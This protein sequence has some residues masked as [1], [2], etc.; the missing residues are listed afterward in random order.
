[1]QLYGLIFVIEDCSCPVPLQNV[2]VEANI[3]DMI[4]ETMVCQTYK[5]VEQNTI[6]AI[7]KF[8]LHEAAAVCGFE[9]EIDGK[10][11][12]KG[13][14]KKQSK[15]QRSHG[16]YLLEEQHPDIFQCSIGNITAGQTKLIPDK[17]SYTDKTDYY[18]KLDIICRMT[19]V[20]QSIE[21]PSHH[22][23][24]E[25]NIDGNPNVSKITL[26]EQIT[27]LEKDLI[28]VKILGLDQPRSGSMRGGPIK[29]ASETLQLLLRSL[30]ENCLFNV[31]FENSRNDMPTSIFLLTN[32]QVYNVDQI[33]ELIKSSEEKKKDD[34]RLFSI[35]IGDS[36]SHH[37]VESFLMLPPIKDYNI[38]WTNQILE[39]VL[40]IETNTVKRPNISF[41]SDN[42]TPLP[43]IQN[44]FM[45]IKIQQAPFLILP[46]YPGT[47]FIVYCILEKGVEPCKE[48]V[49]SAISQDG[50][51][52]LS[53]PLDPITLRGS[54]IHTLSARKLIQDI[55]EGTSFINKHPRNKEK[56]FFRLTYF[57]LAI[58]E[59]GSG[60]VS[61]AKLLSGQRIDQRI[62]PVSAISYKSC[63]DLSQSLNIV[64]MKSKTKR[65]RSSVMKS[66]SLSRMA[67]YSIVMEP[68][69]SSEIYNLKS[70]IL[71]ESIKRNKDSSTL[72]LPAAST[73]LKPPKIKTLYSFLNFQSFDGSIL[74][75]S[76]FYSWFGKNN[77]KDFQVIGIENEKVLCLTL[78]LAYLE[79]IM[80]ETFKNEC[81]MCYEKAKK[82]LKKEVGGDEQKANEILEKAKKW[83]KK[84]VDK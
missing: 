81:E 56:K 14:L 26:A 54:K 40:P 20:I 47:Q 83:V 7:Y 33:V 46:I 48:T 27:H 5:N 6:E 75:S 3:I 63:M 61:E 55:E 57:F 38:T 51:M 52:N 77:F 49:L 11:K 39:D 16:A 10:R 80:F 36:V 78:A 22:I 50:P 53:I 60:F 1:M 28:L 31:A 12:V 13:E 65:S 15:L 43:T 37:L 21:S 67:S 41:F 8:P 74:P 30:P 42:T 35:G 76:K 59:R 62:V 4:A 45:D 79:I 64:S 68:E 24:I 66:K 25:L 34:L 82:V 71:I 44:I 70:D 19:S 58:D 2:L 9:A 32:G 17:M 72:V 73:K 69:V 18:L 29:K 23:S 84:W